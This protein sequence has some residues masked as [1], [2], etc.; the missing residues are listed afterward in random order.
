MTI[1]AAMASIGVATA[2]ADNEVVLCKT[3]ESLCLESNQQKAGTVVKA[4]GTNPTLLGN[5]EQKCKHTELEYKTLAQMG[6]P[7]PVSI[8]RLEFTGCEPC[9]TVTAEN[10]PYTSSISMDAGGP[11]LIVVAELRF[12]LG[13]CTLGQSC[14]FS[15]KGATFEGNNVEGKMEIA[16]KAVELLL[17]AGNKAFCGGSSGMDA[18][19]YTTSPA[20]TYYSLFQL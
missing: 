13:G 20:S 6:N 18:T 8:T 9:K 19:W 7:L 14:T 4:L 11:Y 2:Q 10:V 16:A 12:T 5:L 17:V 1:A 3:T 15:A